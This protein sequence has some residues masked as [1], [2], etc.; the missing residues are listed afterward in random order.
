MGLIASKLS[1]SMVGMALIIEQSLA[2]KQKKFANNKILVYNDSMELEKNFDYFETVREKLAKK[3]HG[4][5]VLIS[6]AK[7]VSYHPTF[8]EGVL[9]ARNRELKPG[10]FIVAEC[11][12]KHEEVPAVFH[13]RVGV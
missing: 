10:N 2:K 8:V 6:D 1:I 12:L 7:V 5:Y 4:K 13:S 11:V 9:E 3:H